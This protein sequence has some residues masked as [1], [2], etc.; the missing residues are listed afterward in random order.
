M[1]LRIGAAL[2]AG[3]YSVA[4]ARLL[5]DNPDPGDVYCRVRERY[6]VPAVR[7]VDRVEIA[8]TSVGHGAC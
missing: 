1:L 8:E 5:I 4:H 2:F 6:V 3:Q 7:A